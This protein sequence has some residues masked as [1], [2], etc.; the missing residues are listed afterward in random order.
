MPFP[1][2][3]PRLP[4]S[5]IPP[6]LRKAFEDV[7]AWMV[8][9]QFIPGLNMSGEET[10]KGIRANA[11]GGAGG[12]SGAEPFAILPASGPKGSS[13]TYL[14]VH[15]HSMLRK[16]INPKSK[17]TI[18]GLDSAFAFSGAGKHIWIK[19]DVTPR[20]NDPP[21]DPTAT[22]QN[23][24]KWAPSKSAVFPDV[25]EYNTSDG[26]KDPPGTPPADL[27]QV[28]FY[29]P[30]AYSVKG[31]DDPF[32]PLAKN[33]GLDIGGGCYLVQQCRSHLI[34][35]SECHKGGTVDYVRPDSSAPQPE[36]S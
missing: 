32:T 4:E 26:S 22:I 14:K 19:V 33:H 35:S 30:L 3:P 17:I 16:D 18:T 7:I 25:I 29:V 36:H 13:G 2:E 12:F 20:Y 11:S 10:P 5:G 28:A 8:A 23:G 9:R 21:G 34:L 27:R 1:C 6:K 15:L 31:D 24:P